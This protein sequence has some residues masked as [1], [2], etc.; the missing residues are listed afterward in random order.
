MYIY[1]CVSWSTVYTYICISWSH[2]VHIYVCK[3]V[4][5]N[6]KTQ[7]AAHSLWKSTLVPITLD[8]YFGPR[9]FV[10]RPKRCGNSV[11][12]KCRNLI[13][14]LPWEE[15]TFLLPWIIWYTTYLVSQITHGRSKSKWMTHGRRKLIS[16]HGLFGIP[17]IW[18]TSTGGVEVEWSGESLVQTSIHQIFVFYIFRFHSIWVGISGDNPN[19]RIH[20]REKPHALLRL[21]NVVSRFSTREAYR[22]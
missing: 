11:R 2:C 8:Q 6:E 13:S 16:S 22:L 20:K 9:R 14:L 15:E 4:P 17:L 3:L 1:R 7:N 5:L 18:C 10:L 19:F 12:C 21:A